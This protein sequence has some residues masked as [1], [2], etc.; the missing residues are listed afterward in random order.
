[1][2]RNY[3]AGVVLALV[4]INVS[5][6]DVW[7]TLFA[8]NLSDARDGD[9]DAQYEVGIMYLKGQGVRPDRNKAIEW[10]TAAAENDNEQAAGKLSRMAANA[11]DFLAIQ[12]KAR[13]GNVDAQYKAGLMLL[14]GKGVSINSQQ[15]VD[16]LA[17]A[18]AQGHEKAATKLGI[19]YYKGNGV[20]ADPQRAVELFNSVAAG[21]AL[22]QYYLGE[23]YAD[24]RGVS[25]DFDT[26][27]DWY[28]KAD[29]NGYRR[30]G[31]KIINLQEEIKMQQR[32]QARLA[33]EQQLAN[34]SREQEKIAKEQARLRAEKE[35]R[36]QDIRD[37]EKRLAKIRAAKAKASKARPAKK[38]VKASK[39]KQDIHYL[40]KKNWD[41]K[42][43]SISFLPSELNQCERDAGKLVCYSR[44]IRESSAGRTIQYRVKSI[45]TPGNNKDSFHVTYRN[46]VLDVVLHEQGDADAAYDDE[47]A[48]GFKVKTGWTKKHSVECKFDSASKISCL[49]DG[50]HRVKVAIANGG[51]D[52]DNS[53][54]ASRGL[55]TK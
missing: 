54:L 8:E 5:A 39:P 55:I 46:L 47:Q 52:R 45:I 41:S 34:Q 28:R 10:L 37:A 19:I 24:G 4:V 43:R 9:A 35:Q 18:A 1:M 6:A 31:G 23:A 49:K 14:A 16:W 13:E 44:K 29:K 17:K 51:R 53:Q 25:R 36:E 21:Q 42:G 33:R 7:T 26:A 2:K 27:I 3:L 20:P 30:A 22:A 38:V 40:V 48:Q 32:L 11:R 50:V 15:A 12:N